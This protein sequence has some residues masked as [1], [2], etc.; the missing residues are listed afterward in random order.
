MNTFRICV[1]FAFIH[2][3]PAGDYDCSDTDYPDCYS[4]SESP[5]TFE[6]DH[7]EN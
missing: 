3:S 2:F 4:P 6:R 7:S 5:F 1:P